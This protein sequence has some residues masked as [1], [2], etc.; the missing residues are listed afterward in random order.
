MSAGSAV[1]ERRQH[2]LVARIVVPKED[3]SDITTRPGRVRRTS[4]NDISVMFDGPV[5]VSWSGCGGRPTI[6]RVSM[7]LRVAGSLLQRD[8]I[9]RG[10]A[11]SLRA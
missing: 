3:V 6:K 1:L 5:R 8:Q 11:Y 2:L 9:D 7:I 4:V 10:T